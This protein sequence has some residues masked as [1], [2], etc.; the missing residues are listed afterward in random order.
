MDRQW[1]TTI[2]RSKV[3]WSVKSRYP[4]A[5]TWS[6][7][8]SRHHRRVQEEEVKRRFAMVTWR[9]DIN[10]GKRRKS[11]EK[12]SILLESKHFQSIPVPSSNSRTFRRKCS[13]SYVARQC[14]ITE[15]IHRVNLPCREP[16]WIKPNNKKWT[17]SRRGKASKEEDKPCSSL[18]WIRLRMNIV[19]VKLHAIKKTKKSLHTRILGNAF[20]IRYVRAIWSWLKRKACNFTKHGHMQSFSATHHLQ[21]AL[22]KR[23]VWKHKRSSTEMFV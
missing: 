2:K 5:T 17:D 1:N 23:Y 12:V 11:K 6:N 21:L 18:Q 9:I 19:R 16:E 20:K 3:F 10:S 13:W 15:R 14:T 22:R 4:I 7:S 8:P